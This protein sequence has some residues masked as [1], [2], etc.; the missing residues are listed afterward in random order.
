MF[1]FIK[2]YKIFIIILLLF[3]MSFFIYSK[4]IKNNSESIFK[5]DLPAQYHNY[6]IIGEH[7]IDIKYDE[8]R[9]ENFQSKLVLINRDYL[10]YMGISKIILLRED[11]YFLELPGYGE[12]FEW[13]QVGD[14]NHNS[15]LDVAVMYQNMGSG[16]FK[17]FYFYEWNGENFEVKL[18]NSNLFNRVELIDIDD[19]GMAEIV[20]SFRLFQFAWPW[21]E[22]Y[23]WQ[24]DKTKGTDGY[25]KANNMFPASYNEWLRDKEFNPNGNFETAPEFWNTQ[26]GEIV[27]QTNQC[28]KEKAILN[29][30]GTFAD[31]DECYLGY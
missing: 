22:I 26:D 28:L 24:Y 15:W 31:V 7:F 12:G 11:G 3:L 25:V 18:H 19:N 4:L 8:N 16:S 9:D 23:E 21:K 6:R 5:T 29:S 10:I 14:L 13:W 2:K 1:E 20:H 17:P 27:L 30:Q